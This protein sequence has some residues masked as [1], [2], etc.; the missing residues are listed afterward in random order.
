MSA[1]DRLLLVAASWPE[2]EP[3]LLTASGLRPHL[4]G[5]IEVIGSGAAE[6]VAGQFLLDG[7]SVEGGLTVLPGDLG[8]LV[9]SSCTMLDCTVG[10]GVIAAAGNPQLGVRLV[11]SVCAAVRLTDAAGLGLT[12]CIVHVD[13]DPQ[14][15]AVDAPATHVEVVAS[16]LLGRITARSLAAS[17]AILLGRVEVERRQQGCVRFSFLPLDSISPRRYRCQPSDDGTH[18][19][20]GIHLGTSR[21]PGLRAARRQLPGGDQRGRRRP[22]RD[23][24]IRLPPA[25]RAAGQPDFA[26][27]YL[28]ALRARSRTLPSDVRC[29]M[30]GDFTRRTFRR[31]NH[32]RGVLLQQGRVALDADW[33]E[34]VEI[35]DHLDRTTTLDTVGRHGA[36]AGD[37]GMEIVCAT[38]DITKGGCKA[39]ELRI[40]NG[41][42]YVDGILCEN[43]ESMPLDAQPDLPGAL[44]NADPGRHIAYLDVWAEHVTVLERPELREVALGGPD[45]ATRSRTIWQ[46]RLFKPKQTPYGCPPEDPPFVPELSAVTPGRL[47]AGTKAPDYDPGPCVIPATA[48]YRRLEN[49]LYRVEIHTGSGPGKTPTWVWSRENGSVAARLLAV[50]GNVLTID[51]PARDERLGFA[52]DNWVEVTD[53]ARVRRGEPGFLGQLD[54]VQGTKLTV[55]SW[56][57]P[58]P[59]VDKLTAGKVVRRWDSDGEL[60]IGT[61]WVGLEDGVEV[62][63]EAGGTY[64]TGDYWLI[65]A[66]SANLDGQPIDP[67]L[68]GNIEWPREGDE[69]AFRRPVGIK[70]HYAPL[71][72]LEL[73]K[74][75]W[76]RVGDCRKVFPPLG[77][78]VDV[79]YAGGD[80]QET[81]PG[82]PVPQP[83]E[84]SVADGAGPVGGALI[85]FAADD[86]DGR[87]AATRANLPGSTV[88]T[89]DVATNPDGLARCYWRPAAD[90][91]RPSQRVTANLVGPAVAGTPVHFSAGLSLA[92][93][94]GYDPDDCAALAGVVT[95]Q[96]ALDRLV[97]AWSLAEVGGNGQA[98][99][100][101]SDLP[102]SAEVLVRNDCG[103]VAGAQVHFTVTSGAVADDGA[104]LATGGPAVDIT[105]GTDGVARC[106]WRLGPD[107]LVQALVAELVPGAALVAQPTRLAFTASLERGRDDAPGLHVTGVTL[108][109][110]QDHQ[111]Q[112]LLND[113]Q[114]PAADLAR[115]VAVVLDDTPL[116][117]LVNEKPVLTLTVDLPYPFAQS[118]RDLWHPAPMTSFVIGTMPLTLAGDVALG[119]VAG[120]PAVTW[121]PTA[122][123]ADF[124]PRLLTMMAEFDRGEQVLCH[125]TLTGRAVAD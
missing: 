18:R 103:A 20:A 78:L 67:D 80:G 66:R 89:V 90:P 46:V 28:S 94:V 71:A 92:D 63:F 109:G 50:A 107:D 55:R 53:S 60:T 112:P 30:K 37:A 81:L 34:Q 27:G 52:R 93:R 25:A 99:P 1:G 7:F 115:G 85:H 95:V 31:R 77:S 40:S 102:L 101:G 75:G 88:S 125:L 43:E 61:G 24:R 2:T 62:E 59:A 3:G 45:T 51:A 123:S 32:Y 68:A 121:T 74:D 11:R 83:L 87:L 19:R 120:E 36:P 29:S 44:L 118:D 14:T 65:P 23:G 96:G 79:E 5:T 72:V 69:P 22:G 6:G 108:L 86:A 49:Q 38:G 105:T 12:D 124:L 110:N 64:R 13:G 33:N 8:G 10:G 97:T 47:R 113:S 56:L 21:P 54:D 42:Y 100:P 48:R 9:V 35:Q 116:A 70:H 58:N 98:G 82:E 57:D 91:S 26:A 111:P 114:L 122:G 73:G 76:R 106:F 104:G 41:R 39:D 4:V 84:I 117:G 119:D 16:T 15:V 17:N